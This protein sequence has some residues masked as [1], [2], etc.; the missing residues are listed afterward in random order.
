MNG[1]ANWGTPTGRVAEYA[2]PKYASSAQDYVGLIN[3]L[4][5]QRDS[6]EIE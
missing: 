5:Q 1:V 2:I 4:K 6:L 3:F